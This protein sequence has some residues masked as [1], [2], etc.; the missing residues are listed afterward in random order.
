MRQLIRAKKTDV[1]RLATPVRKTGAAVL[2]LTQLVLM[3]AEAASGLLHGCEYSDQ[4]LALA[5]PAAA[6]HHCRL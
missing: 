4:S 6:R 5:A 3:A 2:W 1:W